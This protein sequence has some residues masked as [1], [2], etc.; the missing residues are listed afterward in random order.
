MITKVE[1]NNRDAYKKS[2][3]LEIDKNKEQKI[4]V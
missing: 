4:Q 2:V 1:D 3:T